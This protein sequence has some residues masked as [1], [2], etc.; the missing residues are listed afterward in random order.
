MRSLVVFS[1][2]SRL[3]A[4]SLLKSMSESR[5]DKPGGYLHL[6]ELTELTENDKSASWGP[7]QKAAS[8]RTQEPSRASVR[9]LEK[10]LSTK[11]FNESWGMTEES[12]S[13]NL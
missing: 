7:R 13:S 4:V 3:G 6:T 8:G 5:I 9:M 2:W 10:C 12:S 11:I 1:P